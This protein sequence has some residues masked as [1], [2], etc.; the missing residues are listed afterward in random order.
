MSTQP[1]AL[2]HLP[3]HMPA[4]SAAGQEASMPGCFIAAEELLPVWTARLCTA[5]VAVYAQEK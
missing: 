5:S 1:Q 4:A 2:G 3:A